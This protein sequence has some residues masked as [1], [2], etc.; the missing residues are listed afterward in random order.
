MPTPVPTRAKV[1]TRRRAAG[2]SPQSTPNTSQPTRKMII[3][4]SRAT[5]K[6][7]RASPNRMVEVVVGVASMRLDHPEAAGLDQAGRPGQRGDEHEQDEVGR[8]G[9]VE[10]GRQRVLAAADG[11]RLDPDLLLAARQGPGPGQ[12]GVEGDPG[13]VGGEPGRLHLGRLPGHHGRHGRADRGWG[14]PGLVDHEG[15][16]GRPAGP[17]GLVVAGGQDHPGR[18]HAAADRLAEGVGVVVGAGVEGRGGR[19]GRPGA[20]RRA[21]RRPRRRSRRAAA[22]RRRRRR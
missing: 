15:D 21:G 12:G 20:R 9:V 22:R 8:G 2:G 11:G 17:Q 3:P 14:W 18:D 7:L 5:A 1:T 10:A 19:P 6:R 4:W 16:L 13:V